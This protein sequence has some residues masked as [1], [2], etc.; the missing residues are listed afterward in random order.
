[1]NSRNN[2]GESRPMDAEEYAKVPVAVHLARLEGQLASVQAQQTSQGRTLETLAAAVQ[3]LAES[4]VRTDS[5]QDSIRRIWERMEK[6]EGLIGAD[7]KA[8]QLGQN[9]LRNR[10]YGAA[11]VLALLI[12]VLTWIGQDQISSARET[13]RELRAESRRVD[14]RMDRVEVY[15]AGSKER[16]FER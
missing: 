16:P 12:G 10:A 1:M 5:Q 4:A 15:L 8:L 2:R 7:I 3:K 6:A 9:S 14:E 11:A 13:A